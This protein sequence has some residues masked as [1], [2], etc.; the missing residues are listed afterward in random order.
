MSKARVAV[1]TAWIFGLA[2]SG[3]AADSTP[4]P[5]ARPE[6][7]QVSPAGLARM[8]AALRREI[9]R[10]HHAGM[11]VL[12]AR[13]GRIVHFEAMGSRDLKGQRPMEKDTIVRIYSMSKLITSAAVLM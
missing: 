8:S 1:C 5:V 7:Q 6:T 4:L 13:N 10:G 12:L 11:V 3:F 2:L 9:E